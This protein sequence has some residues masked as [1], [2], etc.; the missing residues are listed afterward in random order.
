MLIAM[1]LVPRWIWICHFRMVH[2]FFANF[3][4]TSFGARLRLFRGSVWRSAVTVVCALCEPQL[5]NDK[6]QL[7]WR[8]PS[9]LAAAWLQE[10]DGAEREKE[11]DDTGNMPWPPWSNLFRL[12]IGLLQADSCPSNYIHPFRFKRHFIPRPT[13]GNN[14]YKTIT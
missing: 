11:R 8:L 2:S 7:K 14:S 5:D 6:Q 10:N 3:I 12:K 9:K 1:I 4:S 13:K